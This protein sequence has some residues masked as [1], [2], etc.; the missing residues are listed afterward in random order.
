MTKGNLEKYLGICILLSLII[1]VNNLSQA[2]NKE[3]DLDKLM[4][5][6]YENGIFNGSVLIAHHKK[7]IYKNGWGY[8]DSTT[9]T[10]ITPNTSFYLASVSKQFTAMAVMLLKNQSKLTYQDKLSKYFPDFP[11][12]ADD[13]TIKHLL[14]HTSGIPDHF[15]LGAFRPGLT[16]EDVLK[17]LSDQDSLD[18]A[19]GQRFSYSN[20]GYV[21]LSLIVER[22][23]KVTFHSFMKANIFDPLEMNRTEVYIQSKSEIQNRAIGFSAF[24]ELSDYNILTT[25]DGG[26]FSTVL[27][28]Y[29]WD[30][31]LYDEKLVPH[32]MLSEAFSGMKL[33]D[34]TYTDYGYGWRL[35][36]DSSASAV[37]HSGALNGF[38]TLIYRDLTNQHSII[39]LSNHGSALQRNEIRDAIININD[40]RPWEYPRIPISLKLVELSKAQDIKGVEK[41]YWSLKKDDASSYKFDESE[42]NTF[43]YY[44]MSQNKSKEAQIIFKINIAQ[45]E[46][47][48]NVYDSYAEACFALKEY[49]L[50]KKNYLKSLALNPGNVNARKMLEMISG[51]IQKNDK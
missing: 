43:G 18:F 31:A 41:S 28:L 47:S 5:Y 9:N 42:L 45:F 49:E 48:A 24:G 35:I 37:T 25:G 30:Q 21:L 34:G 17:V 16:N 15:N 1:G 10:A 36:S 32:I 19:P 50:A 51:L 27:D 3:K 33:N 46:N 12:Y 38:R 8:C 44:L 39:L 14:T 4:S 2:Q 22:A 7:I 40:S 26:M 23:S 6:C 11:P 20:G 29:K 13:V